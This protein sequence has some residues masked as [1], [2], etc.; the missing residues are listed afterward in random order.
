LGIV[1]IWILNFQFSFL[2]I[3]F[4]IRFIANVIFTS[5][6]LSSTREATSCAATQELPWILWSP[7]VHY[8]LY[9]IPPL[10]LILSQMN[11]VHTTPPV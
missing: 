7:K 11:P 2:F 10:V 5:L 8:C 1:V 9:K 3:V 6:K 4:I